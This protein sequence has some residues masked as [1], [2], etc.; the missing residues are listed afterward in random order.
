MDRRTL[1]AAL[2]VTFATADA[3]ALTPGLRT[4]LNPPG[5]PPMASI[6]VIA[7]RGDGTSAL[8]LVAGEAFDDDASGL[9]GFRLRHPA[10]P[11]TPVMPRMLLAHTSD[12][13]NGP[14]YPV[15]LGHD[16]SE[17]FTLGGRHYDSGSWFGPQAHRPGDWFAYADVNFALL[18]QILERRT[19]ER[20]DLHMGRALFQPLGLDVGYNWSG[21]SEHRRARAAAGVRRVG[22]RWVV[23]GPLPPQSPSRGHR[24]PQTSISTPTTPAR[25]AFCS[26][27]GRLAIEPR[28][29]GPTGAYAGGRGRLAGTTDHS[30]R[31]VGPDADAAVDL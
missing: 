10:W 30:R 23:Q 13:R 27:P 20:F 15:P 7:R 6:G 22:G 11:D 31:S 8:R 2:A 12:L 9:L 16:L 14:S 17:A 21:V 19:G 3:R 18:A 24:R 28:R 25:M 29:H 26:H 4:I 1:S 5:G